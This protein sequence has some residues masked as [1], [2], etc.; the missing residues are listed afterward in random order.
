MIILVVEVMT[1]RNSIQTNIKVKFIHIL[2]LQLHKS[3]KKKHESI[4][5]KT[6]ISIESFETCIKTDFIK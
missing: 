6:K 4:E 1:H 2:F 5:I 3:V